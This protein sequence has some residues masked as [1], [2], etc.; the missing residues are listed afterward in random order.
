M[1]VP[2]TIETISDAS[3]GSSVISSPTVS[4]VRRAIVKLPSP[5]AN[6]AIRTPWSTVSA[7]PSP[8][9]G[10][11]AFAAFDAPAENAI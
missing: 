2:P 1:T 7:P 8:T 11:T 4:S 9:R 6:T 3:I 10:A 5:K